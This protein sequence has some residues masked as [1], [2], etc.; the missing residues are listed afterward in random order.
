[1]TSCWDPSFK[2]FGIGIQN[3]PHCF[4][5][6]ISLKIRFNPATTLCDLRTSNLPFQGEYETGAIG[7]VIGVRSR[8]SRTREGRAPWFHSMLELKKSL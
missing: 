4:W 8:S 3:H 1:M 5:N 6:Y 7:A 2:M